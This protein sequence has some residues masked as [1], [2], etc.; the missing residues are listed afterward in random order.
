GRFTL[1]GRLRFQE[2]RRTYFKNEEYVLPRY[3]VR[4]KVTTMYRTPSFPV[5][6]YLEF[7]TFMPVFSD[8]SKVIGKNR[9]TAGL[10]YKF[11]KTHAVD[12]EYMFERDYLPKLADIN[13]ISLGY[14]L[15][16]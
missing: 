13:I 16:F 12:L 4:M 10:E 14:N 6:P 1:R 11:N 7:E 2:Q 15:K 3:Q 9:F 8:K 5:N